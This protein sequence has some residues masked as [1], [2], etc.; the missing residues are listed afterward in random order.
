MKTWCVTVGNDGTHLMCEEM[1][2]YALLIDEHINDICYMVL[3][4][5][6]DKKIDLHDI[7]LPKWIP[8]I[9]E[10]HVVT[11]LQDYYGDLGCFLDVLVLNPVWQ[12]SWKKRIRSFSVPVPWELLKPHV[13]TS[14]IGW[15]E[16]ILSEQKRWK[17]EAARDLATAGTDN[18]DPGDNT[19]E[20][21]VG[22]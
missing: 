20:P 12:W 1:P 14:T 18:P 7:Q 13:D 6:K 22:S 19:V 2:W 3:L 9:D 10:D 5:W 17:E 21:Q 8:W 16:E 15:V 11:N 4:H